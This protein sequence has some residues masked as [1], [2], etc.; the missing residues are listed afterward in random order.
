M[1]FAAIFRNLGRMLFSQNRLSDAKWVSENVETVLRRT[2][3]SWSHH[4]EVAPLEPIKFS[5]RSE[6]STFSLTHIFR[7]R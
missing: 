7:S 1:K 5:P 2:N 6:N 4:R 3:L